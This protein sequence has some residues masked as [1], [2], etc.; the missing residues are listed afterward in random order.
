[1]PVK[2]RKVQIEGEKQ[3]E[4]D[5]SKQKQNGGNDHKAGTTEKRNL[6]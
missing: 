4:K 1:M 5:N 2:S 6:Q 3:G